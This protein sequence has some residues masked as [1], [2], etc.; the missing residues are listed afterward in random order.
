MARERMTLAELFRRH[1]VDPGALP[2][3]SASPPDSEVRK[4]I[5]Q[6]PLQ[7]CAACA[8]GK[9]VVWVG[10]Y[11]SIPSTRITLVDEAEARTLA[12]WPDPE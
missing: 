4:R 2:H 12:V 8:R 9:F 11:G 1:G 5:T 3:T 6:A 7:P 10:Q